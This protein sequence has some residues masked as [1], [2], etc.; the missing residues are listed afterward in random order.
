MHC[1]FASTDTPNLFMILLSSHLY[2]F[3]AV[4]EYEKKEEER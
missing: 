4:K 1:H 2:Y 3:G